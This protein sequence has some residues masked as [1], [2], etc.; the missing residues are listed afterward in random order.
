MYCLFLGNWV[1]FS[2]N[3]DTRPFCPYMV[4]SEVSCC[5]WVC[6]S[7]WRCVTETLQCAWRLLCSESW[8]CLGNLW[9]VSLSPLDLLILVLTGG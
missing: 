4:P 1:G 6:P 2:E 5:W 3:G 9:L 7:A 8:S